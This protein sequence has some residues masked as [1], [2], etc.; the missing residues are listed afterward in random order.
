M[1][2][3]LLRGY[4]GLKSGARVEGRESGARSKTREEICL[5]TGS[6]FYRV[7]YGKPLWDKG[8][9]GMRRAKIRRIWNGRSVSFGVA[10]E[11]FEKGRKWEQNGKEVAKWRTV[12][13]PSELVLRRFVWLRNLVGNSISSWS[14]ILLWFS[15]TILTLTGELKCLAVPHMAHLFLVSHSFFLFS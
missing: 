13:H 7:G 1:K 9:R 15:S 3:H 14:G 4:E 2:N 6:G 12:A 10:I 8:L 5:E 11:V